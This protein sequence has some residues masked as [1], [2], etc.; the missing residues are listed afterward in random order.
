MKRMNLLLCLMSLALSLAWATGNEDASSSSGPNKAQ[1]VAPVKSHQDDDNSATAPAKAHDDADNSGD[2]VTAVEV[3][4]STPTKSI[5]RYVSPPD[6]N[7]DPTPRGGRTISP[8]EGIDAAHRRGGSWR[9]D[10]PRAPRAPRENRWRPDWHRGHRPGH[11]RGYWGFGVFTG[12]IFIPYPVPV[13]YPHNPYRKDR[14]VFVEFTGDDIVGSNLSYSIREYLRD[15]GMIP[16]YSREQASLELYIVSSDLDHEDP[17]SASSIAISYIWFPGERFIT[18]QMMQVRAGQ[19]DDRAESIADY[20]D[21]L[22]EEY[23]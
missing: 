22:L 21:Q 2:A 10:H 13:S 8:P 1:V 20:A 9:G 23:H 15:Y 12:P 5:P 11:Y 7:P 6:P 16:V 17:G 4:V 18:S 14:G 3:E 19:V